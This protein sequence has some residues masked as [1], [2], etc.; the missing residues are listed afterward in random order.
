MKWMTFSENIICN[1]S[2]E[3]IDDLNRPI[4]TKEVESII[5]LTKQKVIGP[6]EFTDDSTILLRKKLYQNSIMSS[7]R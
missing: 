2:Q 4:S 6:N 5:N 7:K 3:E 1:N